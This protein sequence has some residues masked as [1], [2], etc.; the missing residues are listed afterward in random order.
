MPRLLLVDD[1]PAIH[2]LA[3]KA[4]RGTDLD[5]VCLRS[6]DEVLRSVRIGDRFDAVLIDLSMP[7]MDGWTLLERL[8]SAP[9]YARI[10][11]A[12]MAGVLDVVDQER[13]KAAP[14][15]AFLLKPVDLKKLPAR[16]TRMLDAAV[17]PPVEAPV[18]A[19]AVAIPTPDPTAWA[20]EAWD[21]FVAMVPAEFQI[22]DLPAGSELEPG[23]IPASPSGAAAEGFEE[24]LSLNEELERSRRPLPR[25][26]GPAGRHP[27]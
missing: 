11:I 19:P 21:R 12:V 1:N 23:P 4:L 16:I 6:G 9:A 5:L 26:D 17:D 20:E 14:I 22:A 27:R 25:T 10:P 7:G 3:A 8:R 24:D 2:A 13:V 18:A 15:Q